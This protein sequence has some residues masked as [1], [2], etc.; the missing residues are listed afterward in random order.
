[1]FNIGGKVCVN[2]VIDLEMGKLNGV[3]FSM[4]ILPF[5]EFFVLF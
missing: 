3:I 4:P 5:L 1:V 2:N